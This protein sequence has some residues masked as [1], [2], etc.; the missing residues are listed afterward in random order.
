MILASPASSGVEVGID[1]QDPLMLNKGE[2]IEVV[3]TDSGVLNPQRGRLVGLEAKRVVVEVDVPGKGEEGAGKTV[4]VWFPR[5]NY[6]ITKVG[7]H[8]EKARI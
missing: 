5:I 1:P 8:E 4:R 3:P 2:L 7:G 6:S